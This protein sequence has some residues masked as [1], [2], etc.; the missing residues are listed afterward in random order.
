M[1]TERIIIEL[2]LKM[3]KWKFTVLYGTI[4]HNHSTLADSNYPIKWQRKH[5]EQ[6]EHV[7]KYMLHFTDC[8]ADIT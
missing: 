8:S 7:Y 3:S 6:I 5:V 2:N 1:G 4:A